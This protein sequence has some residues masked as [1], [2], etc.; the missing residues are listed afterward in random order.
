MG[1]AMMNGSS[2][3]RKMRR[4][5]TYLAF[6]C[7]LAFALPASGRTIAVSPAGPVRSIAQALRSAADGDVIEVH[8]G[9]YNED[10][11][12]DRSV[13]LVGA[14]NV[15]IRGTGR[16]SVVTVAADGCTL[17]GFV[18]EH[19]GSSLMNEDAGILLKSRKNRIVGNHLKDVLF[20]I[21]LL[22][23]DGNYIADNTIH[24][25]PQLDYG[26][27][28]NGIHI[29]NSRYN[30]V[31]RNTVYETRDGIYVEHAYHSVIRSN[32]VHDLRYG[33]HYM[34]SDDNDFEG[35]IFYNNV[36]GAAIMYSSRIRFRRN[37][38]L[39]NRGFASY[40]ILFQADDHCLAEENV[41]ADNAVGIFMEA[42]NESTLR[43]N[44][45]AANDLALQ[46]F[47]SSAG[48]IFEKNNF[49]DNLSPLELEGSQSNNR[50]NGSLAG[51]Y[52]SQYEG[53]DL[54]GDGIGDVP[55]HIEN[56]FEHLEA[57]LPLLRLYLLSPAAQSLVLAERGFPVLE[58]PQETD[59]LPLMKPVTMDWQPQDPA[60]RP[61]R[62][63]LAFTLS[64]MLVVLSLAAFRWGVH[65]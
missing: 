60:A 64:A 41:I 22:Q 62:R 7:C 14:G 40:G 46:V 11:V 34:Y 21:Y 20:G 50:W 10:V 65:S 59:N 35:N 9:L 38:F 44:L 43:N 25:R 28:G 4:R 32:R 36:A 54:D 39:H 42:L 56:V 30:T 27:R 1:P 17:R 31:E 6:G 5:V 58:T 3:A 45:V 49:I 47:T 33:L 29:W 52:W 2:L 26:D 55:Y 18:I 23:S 48:N 19:S 53:F 37:Q 15:V 57:Q 8:A 63:S 12:L 13:Q 61:P 24:G 16:G 51:N